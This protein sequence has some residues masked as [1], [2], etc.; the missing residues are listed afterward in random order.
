MS[1]GEKEMDGTSDT[2]GERGSLMNLRGVKKHRRKRREDEV[3]RQRKRGVRSGVGW[4]STLRKRP[5]H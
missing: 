3:L 4:V 2:V 1:N 5:K